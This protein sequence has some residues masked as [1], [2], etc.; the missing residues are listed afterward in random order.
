MPSEPRMR[1][2]SKRSS[3][4]SSS[5]ID[6]SSSATGCAKEAVLLCLELA[7][8]PQL[9]AEPPDPREF[10][11]LVAKLTA[12][13]ALV[14]LMVDAVQDRDVVGVARA[15]REARSSSASATCCATGSAPSTT[16][17]CATS[18]AARCGVQRPRPRARAP[19]RR[20]QRS[21]SSSPTRR[22]SRRRSRPC[23]AGSCE[24]PPRHAHGG[25]PRA[26]LPLH[27][28]VVL[29][30][31]LHARLP[32][33]L[34]ALPVRE[35]RVA[36]RERRSSSR[37]RAAS[38]EK[39]DALERLSAAIGASDDDAV[40]RARQGA[41]AS[42]AS[43]S[44]SATGLLP[45]LPA[46]LH[47][48]LPAADDRRLHEDRTALL[49]HRHQQPLRADGLTVADQRAFYYTLRLNGGLS[50]VDGAPLIEYRFQT[51]RRPRRDDLAERRPILPGPTLDGGSRARAQIAPTNIGSFIRSIRRVPVLRDDPGVGQQ[52]GGRASSRSRPTPTA[53]SRS[54]RCSR[55]PPM[56]PPGPRAG[57]SCPDRT[58]SAR[59][60]R[61]CRRSSRRSTRPASTPG[62]PANAPLRPM[63]T[64]ASGCGCATVGS[65][66]TA[67]TPAPA[68][69]SRST[70]R[71]TTTS[72]TTR[73]GPAACSAQPTSLP[74][75]RSGSPS[76]PQR[77]APRSPRASRWSSPPPTR[78][79]AR[80]GLA[81]GSRAGRTRSPQPRHGPDSGRDLVRHG[82]HLTGWTFASLPPCA[83]LLKLGVE[84]LLT[85][86]RSRDEHGDAGRLH[87]VLQGPLGVVRRGRPR[88]GPAC[89]ARLEG[90]RAGRVG[91]RRGRAGVH[92]EAAVD[93]LEVLWTVCSEIHSRA[94]ISSLVRP[95]ATQR[96]SWCCRRVRGS[97]RGGGRHR[98]R[99]CARWG[100]R[101]SRSI[102]VCP[103]KPRVER[104]KKKN[105][106]SP[107]PAGR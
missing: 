3:A 50:V 16:G 53:G 87:R 26:V 1:S 55:S 41:A 101:I 13:E 32:A 54:R 90:H 43:A 62:E 72:R 19:A 63:S 10:A 52:P 14:R 18:S 100:R 25:R 45:A 24:T 27:L 6:A 102:R 8:P 98:A 20:A 9:E 71:T 76:S 34:P 106:A 91:D 42:S 65:A 44:S 59:S 37:W 11:E 103:S 30:L 80:V 61:R 23:C 104:S 95:S 58:S 49:R 69:T 93:V 84:V 56:V 68:I 79:W 64:T 94:A 82:R 60:R 57:A 17:S 40:R 22:R 31:A 78:T 47:L 96:R 92:P 74:C 38:S 28:R 48:R 99:A 97:G 86:G 29:Q 83:Y 4:G 21:A 105:L 15:D 67:P 77:P 35:A 33:A 51:V 89:R 88:G 7:G 70:T 2:R 12:D 5:S 81:R 66:A 75:R 85:T 46:V 73:T 107:G 36:D 39:P